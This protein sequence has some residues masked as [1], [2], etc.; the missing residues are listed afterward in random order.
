MSASRITSSRSTVR[1]MSW[2]IHK[3]VGGLDRRYDLDRTIAVLKHYDPDILLLQEVAQDMRRLRGHNQADLLAQALEL[4]PI[5]YPEHHFQVGAYGN[6]TLARWPIFDSTH[7]DLTIGTR[8]RRG[9][10]QAHVRINVKGHQ[11]TLIVHNMHLGLASRERGPQLDRFVSSEPFRKL[12][13]STPIIVGGDLNDLWG[14]LGSKYLIP[15]GFER[16]GTL[17]N[18][19]PSAFPLRPLDGLFFRGRLRLTHFEVARSKLVRMASDHLPIYADFQMLA[20]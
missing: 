3:G 9:L 18:T 11:H 7:L 4:Y 19:F 20:V 6:M 5:F 2:N 12:H 8:K 15:A 14:S 13:R 1:V 16:A 10:L 17:A